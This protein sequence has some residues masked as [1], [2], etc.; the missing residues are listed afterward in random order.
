MVALWEHGRTVK[1][2]MNDSKSYKNG[3]GS[4]PTRVILMCPLESHLRYFT[5]LGSPTKPLYTS[6]IFII[7]NKNATMFSFY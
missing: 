3:H 2:A 4:K 7:Y 6:V 1:S 5:L